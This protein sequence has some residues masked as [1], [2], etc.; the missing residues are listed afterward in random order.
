MN[1]TGSLAD[2]I[3]PDVGNVDLKVVKLNM[4]LLEMNTK[5]HGHITWL[6]F[7]QFDIW[8]ASFYSSNL[9]LIYAHRCHAR[10]TSGKFDQKLNPV[11]P[12]SGCFN[13]IFYYKNWCNQQFKYHLPGKTKRVCNPR[14]IQ[15]IK[16]CKSRPQDSQI[17]K[18]LGE[19]LSKMGESPWWGFIEFFHYLTC[20]DHCHC[21]APFTYFVWQ[22]G[23]FHPFPLC[24]G[25][26]NP[27]HFFFIMFIYLIYLINLFDFCCTSNRL[28]TSIRFSAFLQT[29]LTLKT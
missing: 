15:T 2:I 26:S 6:L 3:W 18:L 17:N 25:Y 8:A 11:H 13:Y 14:N 21:P 1:G 4:C 23:Y 12:L 29:W 22:K 10:V 16:I 27:S 5:A 20:R 7:F 9:T 28:S 19:R 24:C